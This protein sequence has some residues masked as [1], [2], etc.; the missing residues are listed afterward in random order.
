MPVIISILSMPEF[1][2]SN[3]VRP[4]WIGDH[5]EEPGIR[6]QKSGKVV[7][8]VVLRVAQLRAFRIGEASGPVH[9]AERPV[10]W[11]RT[12]HDLAHRSALWFW[13]KFR[14]AGDGYGEEPFSEEG[15]IALLKKRQA[16][17]ALAKIRREHAISDARFYHWRS[18]YGGME[19]SDARRLKALEACRWA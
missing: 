16:G 8:F 11:Q 15:I 6:L 4:E 9:R 10:F 13:P 14:L 7:G 17:V 18:K 5:G 12:P 3:S 19:V 1:G 2:Q